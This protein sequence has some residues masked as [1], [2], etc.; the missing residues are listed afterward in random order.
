V[1]SGARASVCA[2]CTY[3]GVREKE[4]KQT[5]FPYKGVSKLAETVCLNLNHLESQL[6]AWLAGKDMPTVLRA[7]AQGYLGR[8]HVHHI[9]TSQRAFCMNLV[10]GTCLPFWTFGMQLEK[11]YGILVPAFFFSP[12]VRERERE[13]ERETAQNMQ[14]HSGGPRSRVA[15]RFQTL[16]R[17]Y[18]EVV[19]RVCQ[20]SAKS[21]RFAEPGAHPAT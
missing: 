15:M 1:I 6:V 16:F 8:W 19:W 21:N 3:P 12:A 14:I 5:C 18:E 10:P 17:S 4:K 7:H 11:G 9:T 13:K 20:S 2:T